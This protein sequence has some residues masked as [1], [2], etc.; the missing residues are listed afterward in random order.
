MKNFVFIFNRILFTFLIIF[1]IYVGVLINI[2][3]Y[4]KIDFIWNLK[5]FAIFPTIILTLYIMQKNLK[6]VHVNILDCL[7]TC[8]PLI[9]I[10]LIYILLRH[11]H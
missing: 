7:S 6:R 3:D 9:L 10:V 2:S 8:T 11:I 1:W 4:S 5:Y